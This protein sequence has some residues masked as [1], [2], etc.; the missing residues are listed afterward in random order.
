MIGSTSYSSHRTRR[1][2]RKF[3]FALFVVLA[4]I[5]WHSGKLRTADDDKVDLTAG[6][7]PTRPHPEHIAPREDSPSPRMVDAYGRHIHPHP[8]PAEPQQGPTPDSKAYDSDGPSNGEKFEPATPHKDLP[9]NPKLRHEDSLEDHDIDGIETIKET[10]GD[11]VEHEAKLLHPDDDDATMSDSENPFFDKGQQVRLS[12]ETEKN[13][14]T[15]DVDELLEVDHASKLKDGESTEDETDTEEPVE[16]N[17]HIRHPI[18]ALREMTPWSETYSFPTWDECES[19]KDKADALP[20]ML[21]VPFEQSVK[22]V[23][24]DGW[25]DEWIA[26]GR[27]TGPK[28]QEPKIDFVYNCKFLSRG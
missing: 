18:E 23:A 8:A 26:K 25:E 14:A 27:Y 5:I 4:F 7:I 2:F 12:G 19:L 21:H 9:D 10:T 1:S 13:K 11:K 28:L 22:D 6:D 24:L 17:S 16:E 3:Y 15:Q 20:D